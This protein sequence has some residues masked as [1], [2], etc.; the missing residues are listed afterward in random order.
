V[1]R[2]A[3]SRR[4]VYGRTLTDA[5]FLELAGHYGTWQGYWG[6]YLRVGG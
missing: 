6:H 2:C 1:R 5:D 4:R 3:S